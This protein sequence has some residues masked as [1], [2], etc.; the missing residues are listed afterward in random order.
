MNRTRT[1]SIQ[2]RF[3][4]NPLHDIKK[5]ATLFISLRLINSVASFLYNKNP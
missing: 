5:E 4:G 3:L 1:P 2:Y